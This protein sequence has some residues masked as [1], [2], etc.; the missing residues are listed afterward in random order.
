M[1]VVDSEILK[2]AQIEPDKYKNL[3]VRVSGYSA[4]FVNL[5]KELQNEIIMRTEKNKNSV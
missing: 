2:K 3:V 1:N 4:Y 5:D